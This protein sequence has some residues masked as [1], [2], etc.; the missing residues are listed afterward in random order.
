MSDATYGRIMDFVRRNYVPGSPL[1]P[2]G[3][4]VKL[5]ID[6]DC[7]PDEPELLETPYL[8]LRLCQVDY[9]DLRRRAA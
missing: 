6:E 9:A 7:A 3:V 8:E 5:V 4:Q 1:F 2:L